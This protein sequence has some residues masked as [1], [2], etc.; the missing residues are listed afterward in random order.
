MTVVPFD[1]DIHVG[2]RAV[3]TIEDCAAVLAPWQ[4]DPTDW[5]VSDIL[6]DGHALPEGH[7]LYVPIANFLK[8]PAMQATLEDAW[9]WRHVNEEAA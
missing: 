4:V 6:I 9:R 8:S 7:Y 1:F 3:A 2:E 5:W